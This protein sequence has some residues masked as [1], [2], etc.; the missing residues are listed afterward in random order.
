MA[1]FTSEELR[2]RKELTDAIIRN[3]KIIKKDKRA[4]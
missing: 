4:G 3:L 2:K 1:D